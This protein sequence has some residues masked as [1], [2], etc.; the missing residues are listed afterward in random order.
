MAQTDRNKY[1]RA[2]RRLDRL[3]KHISQDLPTTITPDNI[4]A[5]IRTLEVLVCDTTQVYSDRIKA[6][7]L[8]LK[9]L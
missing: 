2:F 3:R 6:L 7:I 5:L 4:S 9:N 8:E 1:R